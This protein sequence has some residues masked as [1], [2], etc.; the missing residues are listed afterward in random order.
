MFVLRKQKSLI[1][2]KRLWCLTD[3]AMQNV[4]NIFF[5]DSC[6]Y[7]HQYSTGLEA[8]VN[9][10][11]Q[12]EQQAAHEYLNLAV[13]F[14]HP[15][16]SRLGTGGFFIRMYHEELQHMEDLIQYQLYRGGI[17]TI[18]ALN[19]PVPKDKITM[20]EAFKHVLDM[21]H[22]VTDLIKTLV[23][24]AEKDKDYHCANFLITVFLKEQMNSIHNLS[25]HVTHIA[26]ISEDPD[27]LHQYDKYLQTT[28]PYKSKPPHK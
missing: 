18:K 4:L 11:I 24:T 12:A 2:S 25:Q 19:A 1:V 13:S 17:P 14:L 26:R 6:Y 3:T 16:V 5:S 9:K 15:S 28:Y 20:L 21:E 22:C 23:S 8:A 27:A 10:Q 7:K